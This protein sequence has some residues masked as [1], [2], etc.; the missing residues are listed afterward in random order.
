MTEI[1]PFRALRYDPR[2]VT[3]DDVIAPPY[4]VVGADAVAALHARS[5]YNAAHLENPAGAG[6]T[7][8]AGAKRTLDGWL[9][10]G[11]LVRD[12]HPALYVYEQR[13]KIEGRWVIRRSFFARTRLHRP[14][15]GI[16]RPHEATLSGPR[17]ERLRLIR[18]TRTNISPVFG[19]F[20]DPSHVARDVVAAVARQ[21]PD[22]EA[23][24]GLGDR[25]RLWAVTDRRQIEAL[26]GVLAASNV[27]IADGHHR[28]H[29]ALDY[30]DE[31]AE[32]AGRKWTGDEPENFVLMGL[33][34]ED[35][36]G[37]VILPIHRLIHGDTLPERFLERLSALYRVDLLSEAGGA[38]ATEEAWQR[39]QANAYGPTA[40][41][42][43]GV[44]GPRSVHLAV[45]RSQEA[46][47]SAMPRGLSAASKRL[48]AIVLT[49]TV[50]APIFGIDRAA[51]AAGERVTFTESVEEAREAVE[52][53]A[54]RIAILINATRAAQ[55]TA[56]ADAGEVM[57]QKSTYFYPKL[58]TGL[59]F[60]SLDD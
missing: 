3:P 15:E 33:I 57:P 16:V 9:K 40:F 27:T 53:G 24:D 30:R 13:A 48:D 50:L 28:T 52:D 56:V 46:I 5:P 42:I 51:L 22:F 43:L 21:D 17:E 14:E 1:R 2:R 49:E 45:A 6:D 38:A 58:A 60:N 36:P 11:A 32:R 8:F 7:R 41:A 47:D 34:P 44:D 4:D 23:H 25:H 59:V 39:V 19:M 54:C 10:D 35:D 31:C 55:I 37:L 29:T 18:A 12:A 26:S 20:L